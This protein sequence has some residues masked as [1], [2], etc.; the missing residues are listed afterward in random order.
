MSQELNEFVVNHKYEVKKDPT[1]GLVLMKDGQASK[2]HFQQPM[3]VAGK[4]EGS[5]DLMFF[6][7]GTRCTKAQ[8]ISKGSD[9]YFGQECGIHKTAFK[10]DII[11]D[12]HPKPK[13]SLVKN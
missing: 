5:F 1:H 9:F 7:C 12:E 11:E 2:C 13:L 6:P 3:P 10:V 8:L 4:L